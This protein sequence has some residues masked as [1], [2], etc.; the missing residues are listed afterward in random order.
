MEMI[1]QNKISELLEFHSFLLTFNILYE[2]V[3]NSIIQPYK[4][5]L[6]KIVNEYL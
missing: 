1:F 6:I 2:I 4:D 3:K 5:Y